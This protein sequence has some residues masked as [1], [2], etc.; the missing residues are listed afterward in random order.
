MTA[1]TPGRFLVLDGTDGCGKS[2]QI[3]LLRNVFEQR[4]FSVVQTYD[5][6][7][8]DIGEQIRKLLK[9]D[10]KGKMDVHTETMLFMASRAQLV[11]EVIRPALSEGKIVLCDRFVSSTCAYQGAGGYPIGDIIN[12]ARYAIGETW[13]DLT[14]ILDLPAEKGR[15][16]TGQ[17][18]GQNHSNSSAHTAEDRFDSRSLEYYQRVRQGFLALPQYYPAPVEIVNTDGLSIEEVHQKIAALL[19]ERNWF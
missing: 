5:P 15:H 2:T 3:P 4:G 10:A 6:G 14:I 19:Q 1:N 13:P 9:Y 7:G 8:T 17:R 16:R 12:L 18:N 11:S